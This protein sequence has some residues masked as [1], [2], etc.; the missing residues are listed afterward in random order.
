MRDPKLRTQSLNQKSKEAE[1]QPSALWEMISAHNKSML[2]II[3]C[4]AT[5]ECA[6]LQ[7]LHLLF[8]LSE[9]LCKEF[10]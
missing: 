8:H 3:N 6:H 10:L 9:L 7:S 4:P 2:V 1:N 5:D